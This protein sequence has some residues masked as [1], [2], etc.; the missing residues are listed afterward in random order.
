MQGQR[1]EARRLCPQPGVHVVLVQIKAKRR[2]VPYSKGTQRSDSSSRGRRS[3]PTR[4]RRGYPWADSWG[5]GCRRRNAPGVAGREQRRKGRSNHGGGLEA[6]LCSAAS[7]SPAL[8]ATGDTSHRDGPAAFHTDPLLASST[9]SQPLSP[10]AGD[11]LHSSL[12][13]PSSM[14]LSLQVKQDSGILDLNQ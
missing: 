8:G 10:S 12:S 1:E 11:H 6:S 7:L 4:G 3:R 5:Q 2:W 13:L 9:P 14:C